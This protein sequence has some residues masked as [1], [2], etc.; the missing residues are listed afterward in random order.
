MHTE[1]AIKRTIC[2]LIVLATFTVTSQ[3]SAQGNAEAAL[4]DALQAAERAA[5]QSVLSST[6]YAARVLGMPE[7]IQAAVIEV[8]KHLD[9]AD[10]TDDSGESEQPKSDRTVSE[11]STTQTASDSTDES[12]DSGIDG[13][14][15][16]DETALDLGVSSTGRQGG[17]SV[18]E[19]SLDIARPEPRRRSSRDSRKRTPDLDLGHRAES[20]GV[21]RVVESHFHD[22]QSCY[23]ERLA[24]KPKLSGTVTL[25]F[26]VDTDGNAISPVIEKSSLDDETVESCIT[27]T[28]DTWQFPEPVSGQRTT[29]TFPFT[30]RSGS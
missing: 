29:W 24:E 8:T 19:E 12:S 1:K 15:F 26:M 28:V 7:Q 14:N 4:D 16:S 22:V 30:F 18:R 17:D 10:S 9:T 13:M 25:K 5:G 27:D 21:T 11:T 6:V 3:A 2:S 20:A 23:T